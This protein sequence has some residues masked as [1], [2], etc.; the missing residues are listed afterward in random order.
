MTHLEILRLKLN[1]NTL[2]SSNQ[3]SSINTLK[4]R[5]IAIPRDNT[6]LTAVTN[7][8]PA[9]ISKAA[10]EISFLNAEPV[11]LVC[12]FGSHKG[13][14]TRPAFEL[15]LAFAAIDNVI[16]SSSLKLVFARASNKSVVT[17]ASMY[18]IVPFVSVNLV[19]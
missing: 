18:I 4:S 6:E 9:R 19:N 17:E 8:K 1:K 13:V 10:Q 16:S 3:I 12:S 14:G 5:C 7:I 2:H 15:V 11:D